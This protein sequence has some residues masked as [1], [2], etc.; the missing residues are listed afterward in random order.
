MTSCSVPTI[1]SLDARVFP[2][3]GLAPT[4]F[5]LPIFQ[6]GCAGG[7]IGLALGGDITVTHGTTLV[8]AIE[9]CSLLYQG[10]DVTPGNIVGSTIFGDGAACVVLSPSKGTL[11][12]CA[13]QSLLIPN[14]YALM[15]YDI[16]DDGAHLHLDREIPQTLLREAP[17]V[18]ES[19]LCRHNL[20]IADVKW[21]LFHPGGAKI[22]QGLEDTIGL[23]P[24]Q[25]R[26]SWGSLK[27]YG[28]MSS[29]SI[30][31]ALDAFIKDR[32]YKRGDKLLM[33]GI[34]P[35]LTL[36]LNLLECC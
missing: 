12:I 24:E 22:L 10:E 13:S 25:T 36:Q 19:F 15:G 21:W 35:G 8:V 34:G 5:R 1:P 29:A 28:N 2:E 6:Y 27:D 17:D 26:W 32:T 9:L 30:L 4:T 18:I 23:R 16:L 20:S 11:R 3:I 33:L 7:A 31:F 14:T